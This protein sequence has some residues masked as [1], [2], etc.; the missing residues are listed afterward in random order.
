V[1]GYRQQYDVTADGQRFLVNVGADATTSTM[2]V[3]S[4]WLAAARH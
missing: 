1:Y 3:V 2:N 4:N